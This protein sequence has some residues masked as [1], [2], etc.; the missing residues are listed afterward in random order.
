MA[1]FGYKFLLNLFLKFPKDN[2]TP[3]HKKQKNINR[4][5]NIIMKIVPLHL[6]P[7]TPQSSQTLSI[8]PY[9]FP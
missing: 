2:Q 4:L 9:G 1:I 7:S 6:T 3:K 8:T 5:G